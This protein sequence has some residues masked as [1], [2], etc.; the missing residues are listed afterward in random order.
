MHAPRIRPALAAFVV[1]VSLAAPLAAQEPTINERIARIEQ[2]LQQLTELAA[3]LNKELADLKQQLAAGKTTDPAP[4]GPLLWSMDMK[5]DTKGS[6]AIADLDGDGKLELVFGSYFNEQRLF[7]VD[8]ATGKLRW[9]H[10]SDGGPL[11]ASVAIADLDGDG[12][13]E[14]LAA[15]SASG[16]L[17]CL[18]HDGKLKFT[19]KLPSGTDSPAAIADLDGDGVKE[20]IAGSMWQR[21]G[22]GAVTC[23]RADTQAKVWEVR[24]KGCV[25]SEPCLVDLDGDKVLDVIVTSWRGDR[26]VH[27]INGKTGASIWTYTTPGDVVVMGMYHGVALAP[28]SGPGGELTILVG[29]CNGD[30]IALTPAGQVRWTKHVDDYL[31]APITVADIDDDGKPEMFVGGRVLRC[32][33]VEDG[34]ERW[35]HPMDRALER[36]VAITDVDGDGKPDVLFAD[37][38]KVRALDAATGKRVFE[39]NAA[40]HAGRPHE[41][42]SSAPI[43]ADMDG[44]GLREAFFV[45]GAGTSQDGGKGNY[46]RAFVLRLKGKGPDWLTFRGNLR[47]DGSAGR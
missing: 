26:G 29:T 15:D 16:R 47:R 6:G 23:Y 9:T 44:D 46:G 1:L 41:E 5:S 2:Q 14:V 33:A 35:M 43:V 45:I 37:G 20:I 27:A 31:F 32:L 34:T 12:K 30:I 39:Y 13:L 19:I 36:G 38:R 25:Q 10:T 17:Y 3:N 11:D 7:C 24:I 40:L 8:A 22:I 4:A 18:A 28:G 42:I 21:D